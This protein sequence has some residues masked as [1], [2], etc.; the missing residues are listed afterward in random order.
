MLA[1]LRAHKC[2]LPILS[3]KVGMSPLCNVVTVDGTS[4]LCGAERR[5]DVNV[6]RKMISD[7]HGTEKHRGK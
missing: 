6:L 5:A 7:V 4:Q 2:S 1:S 3:W